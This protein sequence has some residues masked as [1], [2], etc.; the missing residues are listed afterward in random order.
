V[1][2]LARERLTGT[3]LTTHD[4]LPPCLNG[5][6]F[7]ITSIRVGGLGARARDEAACLAH[8]IVAQETV[9]PAGF[10]MAVRTIPVIAEYARQIA[11]VDRRQRGTPRW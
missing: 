11:A 7:V 3:V 4:R 6:D 9:G 5:A 8:G 10:A 1:A 2:H